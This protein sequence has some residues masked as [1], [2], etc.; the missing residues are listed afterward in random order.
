MSYSRSSDIGWLQYHLTPSIFQSGSSMMMKSLSED[1]QDGFLSMSYDI[2]DMGN[3]IQGE[4]SRGFS[5]VLDVMNQFGT[6]LAWEN[7]AILLQNFQINNNLQ[8]IAQV[9]EEIHNTLKSPHKTQAAEWRNI[10]LERIDRGLFAKALEAFDEAEKLDDTDFMTLYNKAKIYFYGDGQSN[11]LIDLIKAG[12]YFRNTLTYLNA[13]IKYLCKQKTDRAVLEQLAL[14][15]AEVSLHLANW[16]F[17]TCNELYMHNGHKLTEDMISLY[18]S[19]I[20]NMSV[21]DMNTP[22]GEVKFTI[23]KAYLMLG[24]V[25]TAVLKARTLLTHN[26]DYLYK[27]QKDEDCKELWPH[28]NKVILDIHPKGSGN[29]AM[30]AY[31]LMDLDQNKALEAAQKAILGDPDIYKRF[32]RPQFKPITPQID[33]CMFWETVNRL[34]P[35]IPKLNAMVPLSEQ[36]AAETDDIVEADMVEEDYIDEEGDID[37]TYEDDY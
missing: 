19:I 13:E 23:V 1:I 37:D 15:N 20:E 22:S 7:Y 4:L 28:L 36:D 31:V 6:L 26:F 3:R 21:V 17:V 25:E 11:K 35:D 18:H 34:E 10:G 12:Q 27:L 9:L 14:L 2:E 16:G 5:S 32:L 24:D 29:L 30:Q 8:S 33:N